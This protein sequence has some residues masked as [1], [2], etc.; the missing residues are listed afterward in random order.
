[1]FDVLKSRINQQV[2]EAVKRPLSLEEWE[3]FV[4]ASFD[5][6]RLQS[7]RIQETTVLFEHPELSALGPQELQDVKTFLRET[8]IE[9]LDVVGGQTNFWTWLG[10]SENDPENI[11]QHEIDHCAPL[12]ENIR[13]AC[14]IVL[15]PVHHEELETVTVD[16]FG[17]MLA[18][19]ES[20]SLDP[21]IQALVSSEPQT[22]SFNDVL[23]AEHYAEETHDPEFISFI[24]QRVIE[25]KR[26]GDWT[27]QT[28]GKL[29]RSYMERWMRIKASKTQQGS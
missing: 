16:L 1:M 8:F 14:R 4:S 25:R 22:L 28:K 13:Q 7:Q 10:L 19:L 26:I 18:P 27:P 11:L 21:R 23:S 29:H 24:K 20:E 17:A 3:A 2:P 12:P 6:T 5:L 9:S 15:A